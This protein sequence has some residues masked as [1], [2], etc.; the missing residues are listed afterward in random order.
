MGVRFAEAHATRSHLHHHGSVRECFGNRET[1]SQ[2][3]DRAAAAEKSSEPAGLDST[4]KG[5]CG[6]VPLI[7]QFW[8]VAT[9]AE[10]PVTL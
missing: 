8:T 2:S 6:P 3:A 10:L 5:N 1:K 7:G 9:T 4:N